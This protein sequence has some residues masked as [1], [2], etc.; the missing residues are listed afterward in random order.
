MLL[1]LLKN[2]LQQQSLSSSLQNAE[3]VILLYKQPTAKMKKTS[4][5]LVFIY[6]LFVVFVKRRRELI[7]SWSEVN[8]PKSGIFKSAKTILTKKFIRHE[9][10][11]IQ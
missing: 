2:W 5:Y 6:L 7:P 10:N 11:M 3:T 9:G 1:T 4:I 8:F